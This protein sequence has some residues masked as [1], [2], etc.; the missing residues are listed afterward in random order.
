MKFGICAGPEMA[1]IARDAGFDYFEWSVGG[2]LKPREDESAFEAALAQARAVGIPC[3]AVNV[4]FPP[5]LKVTGPQVDMDA[6]KS[7][8]NTVLRRAE[9]AGLEIIGFGAGGARRVPE[10]FDPQI[11]WRQ[12]VDFCRWL[13]PAAEKHNVTIGVEPL[14][15]S[16]TNILNTAEEAARLIAEVDHPSIRLEI[17]GYHWAKDQNALSGILDNA[18]L[19]VHAHVAAVEGRRA[20]HPGDPC[21]PF[22][23]VLRQIGYDG[24]L[25]IEGRVDNPQEELPQA[26]RI[27]RE[28]SAG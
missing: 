13:G 27:M 17:D 10:G 28:Q 8:M 11:A 19:I 25:S 20:P 3:P 21:A 7:Y 16:E 1:V 5:D 4:L 15:T 24:R 14:N 9:I 2:L 6:I 12:L 18:G 22:F 23:A 26:L